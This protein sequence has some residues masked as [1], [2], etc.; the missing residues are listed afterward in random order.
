MLVKRQELLDNLRAAATDQRV[1]LVELL[2]TVT[3]SW[4]AVLASHEARVKLAQTM[5]KAARAAT[6]AVRKQ[7][8]LAKVSGGVPADGVIPAGPSKKE[9]KKRNA[10]AWMKHCKLV[11][12][13]R[14]AM[15]S[16]L[17]QADAIAQ[18]M[19]RLRWQSLPPGSR[20]R[21][22]KAS[23]PRQ[24]EVMLPFRA[25]P[26]K[27][28]VK[29]AKASR[30][31]TD[32]DLKTAQEL[33]ELEREWRPPSQHVY[34]RPR[35]KARYVSWYRCQLLPGE[36]E[37]LN[38]Q[39]PE[40]AKRDGHNSYILRDL[41]AR[42]W[43][44]PSPEEFKA[45]DGTAISCDL[46]RTDGETVQFVCKHWKLVV[47]GDAPPTKT[48]PAANHDVKQRDPLK[49]AAQV[50]AAESE[51]ARVSNN[52]AAF[53][54]ARPGSY[55]HLW[56]DPQFQQL[57]RQKSVWVVDPGKVSTQPD[58]IQLTWCVARRIESLQPF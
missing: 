33:L 45:S 41:G 24:R 55:H 35:F 46:I 37:F 29:G 54:E 22:V 44:Q 10:E 1:L 17:A 9:R 31:S 27:V 42:Q 40:L 8:K 15:D 18:E 14:A 20:E 7:K 39:L 4:L 3:E 53:L 57:L 50:L 16:V 25:A 11:L 52:V 6:A 26:V 2:E 13:S 19:L 51:S 30:P 47:A 34:P 32:D 43:A 56:G 38:A 21:A 5:A 36:L 23:K 12:S 58:T 49:D 48:S 28:R